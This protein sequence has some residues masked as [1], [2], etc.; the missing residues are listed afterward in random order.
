MGSTVGDLVN[1]GWAVKVGAFV[2]R[3]VGDLVG[4]SKAAVGPADGL[5]VGLAEGFE[6]LV[7]GDGV[8]L[9][10]GLVVGALEGRKLG[11]GVDSLLCTNKSTAK[12]IKL[13]ITFMVLARTRKNCDVSHYPAR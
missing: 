5:G 13:Q 4:T 8:G 6:G 12:V 9:M 3:V 10:E 2:G 7:V 1:E 11:A